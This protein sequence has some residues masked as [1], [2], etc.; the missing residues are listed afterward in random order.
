MLIYSAFP[1]FKFLNILEYLPVLRF[2]F[3]NYC[4]P[5]FS[6]IPSAETTQLLTELLLYFNFLLFESN[7]PHN[8][9]R[10]KK[11]D[12]KK[13]SKLVFKYRSSSTI[14][15]PRFAI[16]EFA[17][18]YP[19]RWEWDDGLLAVLSPCTSDLL[20]GEGGRKT[21]SLAFLDV[22]RHNT[23]GMY[24]VRR[25]TE[26]KCLHFLPSSP[27]ICQPRVKEV[28]VTSPHTRSTDYIL[29]LTVEINPWQI[30]SDVT[31]VFISQNSDPLKKL[32]VFHLSSRVSSQADINKCVCHPHSANN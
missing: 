13:E 9:K 12:R 28:K 8:P 18:S 11:L 29:R 23:G 5:S 31:A 32:E 24:D 17:T 19:I 15:I 6:H 4:C 20:H 1:R 14:C 26:E 2:K 27:R 3:P 21:G 30:E 10:Q 25:Q 22:F 16:S 7:P